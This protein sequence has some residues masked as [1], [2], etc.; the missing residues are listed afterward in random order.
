MTLTL[1][2]L[3]S[4]KRN[5]VETVDFYNT[6]HLFNNR[7]DNI[8]FAIKETPAMVPSA[9]IVPSFLSDFVICVTNG[10]FVEPF[11]VEFIF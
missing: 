8:T 4:K 11:S 1:S 2:Y 3:N 6:T 9:A 7:I 5:P 10:I